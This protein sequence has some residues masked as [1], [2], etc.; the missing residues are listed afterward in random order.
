[1][2]FELT[3]EQKDLKKEVIKFAKNELCDGEH[4]VFSKE[5]WQKCVDFGLI[6]MNVPEE[7]GGMGLDYQTSAILL[8]A[9][10]YACED[11]GFIFAITNHLWVCQNLVNEMGSQALK[12]KYLRGMVEGEYIGCF[13]ITEVESGSDVF[14]MQTKATK[15]CDEYILNGNKMFI[16]NAPIADVFVVVAKTENEEGKETL[17]AFFVEKDFP[18]VS[19]GKKISKMGLEACPMAELC[20][21]NCR[22]PKEN[23]IYK[24][25]KGM[26]VANYALQMERVFEFASHIGAM[27][28]QMEKCIKYANERKQFDKPIKEYQSISNKIVDM[29]V[30]IELAQLLL[31]KIAWKAD[32]KKNIFLDSSIF[33]LFVSESYVATCLDTIQIH[34]AYGYSKEYG[35]ESELRDSIASTIYSGTSETQRNIIFSLIDII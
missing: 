31:F 6:G 5:L 23:I 19:I 12:D 17:T 25:H 1:M 24:E 32:H 35:L 10:G 22:V 11:S 2:D 3:K 15:D 27:E 8:Q 26:K 30:K 18:G 33:K 20:L 34:G 14:Q 9:L 29:K 16:S 13:A 4:G 7:Y 28:R 21:N